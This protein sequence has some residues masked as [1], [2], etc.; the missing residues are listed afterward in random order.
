MQYVRIGRVP[1][2]TKH[3]AEFAPPYVCTPTLSQNNIAP[4]SCDDSL[5]QKWLG[6]W[7]G[8]RLARTR[9]FHQFIFDGLLVSTFFPPRYEME[10]SACK[11]ICIFIAIVP[12]TSH[13]VKCCMYV[14]RMVCWI[15]T[16]CCVCYSVPAGPS[17]YVQYLCNSLVHFTLD[18]IE[19]AGC[20]HLLH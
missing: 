17:L 2:V 14:L 5:H 9:V 7:E 6:I 13:A 19:S 10:P 1:K 11:N 20:C 4:T 12:S 15:S 16:Y 8:R 3:H 18:R